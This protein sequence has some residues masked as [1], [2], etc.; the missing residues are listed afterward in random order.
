M[1][2]AGRKTRCM[3]FQRQRLLPDLSRLVSGGKLGRHDSS[4]RGL[5]A[6]CRGQLIIEGRVS[7]ALVS[8]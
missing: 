4:A 7:D 5:H 2:I 1:P 8:C 3:K 6:P